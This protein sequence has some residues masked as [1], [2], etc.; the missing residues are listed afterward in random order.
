MHRDGEAHDAQQ[1]HVFEAAFAGGETVQKCTTSKATAIS[2]ASAAAKKRVNR[3]TIRQTPPTI[4]RNIAVT[5][6]APP[7]T[8]PIFAMKPAMPVKPGP[9]TLAQPCMNMM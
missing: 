7:G 4:S 2:I 3:P 5:A 6:K 1:Q 8:R 9:V